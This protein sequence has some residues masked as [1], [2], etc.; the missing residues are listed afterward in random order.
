M[1][2]VIIII[3]IIIIYQLTIVPFHIKMIKSALKKDEIKIPWSL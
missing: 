2:R 1:V 3:I